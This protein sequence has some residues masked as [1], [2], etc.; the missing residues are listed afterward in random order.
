MTHEDDLE[1]RVA[2]ENVAEFEQEEIRVDGT[3]VNLSDNLRASARSKH[4]LV[5]NTLTHL[6]DKDVANASQVRI[7]APIHPTQ[8]NSSSTKQQPTIPRRL[9]FSSNSV[10][11]QL[12]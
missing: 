7:P 8:H 6:I 5:K 10:S 9:P 2:S 1:V 12:A 11:D 4:T 3:F